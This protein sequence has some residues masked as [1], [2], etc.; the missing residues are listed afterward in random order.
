MAI[1]Y[2]KLLI[3]C[4]QQTCIKKTGVF[5]YANHTR[6]RFYRFFYRI[7]NVLMTLIFSHLSPCLLIF[8]GSKLKLVM[9]KISGE[10]IPSC[11]S[12]CVLDHCDTDTLC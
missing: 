11:V 4:H 3:Y 7:L 2:C 12:N 10:L 5:F 8:G 6:L 9:P 1:N